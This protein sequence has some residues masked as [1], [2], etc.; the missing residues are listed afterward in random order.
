QAWAEGGWFM[1]AVVLT[2]GVVAMVSAALM[3]FGVQRG[4]AA[5]LANA[6]LGAL[7]TAVGAL[8]FMNGM[9]GA[10]AAVVHASPADRATIM[11]GATAESLTTSAFGMAGAA[12]LLASLALGCLFGVVVQTGVA[13]KLLAFSG[14]TFLVLAMLSA[15]S[16]MRLSDLM[17]LFKAVAHVNPIDRGR[18]LE[19]GSD[20]LSRFNLP[21]LGLLVLL[22]VIVAAGAV[23]LKEAP[24]LAVLLPLLGF[25]GLVGLGAHAGARAFANQKTSELGAISPSY[26]LVDFKGYAGREPQWC[27]KGA[28]VRDCEEDRAIDADALLDE[29]ASQVRRRRDSAYDEKAPVELPVGI[30]AKASAAALW[31]FI[32]AARAANASGVVLTGEHEG[33]PL[34]VAGEIG[35]LAPLL[36]V[37]WSAVPVGLLTTDA[38]CEQHCEVGSVKGDTLVVDGKAFEAMPMVDESDLRDEVHVRVEPTLSPELLV[39]L[40]RDA[41]G[42]GRK[43]VLLLPAD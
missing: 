33:T 4:S 22:A 12:G 39:K 34:K 27:L 36:Q 17:G 37:R 43:L 10:A 20:E 2:G 11:A 29:T 35:G 32:A 5:V 21:F 6:P 23:S 30:T 9:S 1:Y 18:I 19:M 24:R 38:P 7:I 41:A 31:Q 25:G 3:F 40:A 13:R 26:G 16:L 8:G 28:E 42:N 14:G 15:T